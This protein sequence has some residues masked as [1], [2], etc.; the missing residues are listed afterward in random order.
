MD[1]RM[2]AEGRGQQS[3]GIEPPGG[4]P[5]RTACVDCEGRIVVCRAICC[6]LTVDLSPQDLARGGTRSNPARLNRLARGLDGYC[7]HLDRTTRRC[8]IYQFRPAACRAYDCRHDRRIW[9]DF[10]FG[11]LN[12]GALRLLY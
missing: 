7:L 1:N 11:I 10:D 4:E 5:G 6:R 9:T 8:Q 3:V 12:P 2:R